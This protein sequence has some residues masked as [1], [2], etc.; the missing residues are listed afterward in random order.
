MSRLLA[1]LTPSPRSR[2]PLPMSLLV[3][4]LAAALVLPPLPL[5]R[6]EEVHKDVPYV[7]TPEEVVAEM[8]RMAKVTKDDVV[9]DLGCGDGRIVVTAAK[10]HGARGVGVDI[11]PQ[12][13]KESN[14]NAEKA[15]VTDR[16][17]FVTDDLFKMDFS[18]ATVL[19]LYL[20]TSVNAKLKPKI[21]DLKPGTRV[22]SHAFDMGDWEPD[23]QTTVK[24]GG[25]SVFFW[26]VPAKV[27]GTW[28]VS[29]KG[30]DGKEQKATLTLEQ[31][32]QNVTGSATV[33]G[34]KHQLKDGKLGGE[35]DPPE[36]DLLRQ[37]LAREKA[38][39]LPV[40]L[41]KVND[42]RE[43]GRRRGDDEVRV[44]TARGAAG[45]RPRHVRLKSRGWPR[46]RG[47]PRAGNR[48]GP[49]PRPCVEAVSVR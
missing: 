37:R 27:A 16:V 40:R 43:V 30:A 44:E 5:L 38:D 7:P 14:E 2:R 18:E 32:Y 15:G 25:Q 10:E 39:G 1:S 22:V 23:Q 12:R 48:R 8:L 46:G 9:Y 42:V 33:G 11:D 19:T 29:I 26:V 21:L 3:L 6:A 20:L 31:A 36:V 49:S 24:P 47:G 28:D 13:I 35:P 41:L 17:K 34:K 4:A 45:A